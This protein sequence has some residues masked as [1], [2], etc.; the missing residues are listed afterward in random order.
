[1]TAS[2]G[3]FV[4]KSQYDEILDEYEMLRE[5]TS[6][7]QENYIK[8]SKAMDAIFVELSSVSRSTVSLKSDIESGQ[9]RMT[10]AEQ[11]ENSIADIKAQ[12]AELEALSTSNRQMRKTIANLKQVI[13]AKEEEI[14]VLKD[15][16]RQ[17]D[18]TISSQK[19]T[20][21]NQEVQISSQAEQIN[22]HLNTITQQKQELQ[23]QVNTQ[24]KLLYQAGIDFEEIADA[25]PEIRMK[26]NKTKVSNWTRLMY[27]HSVS[28]LN[29]ALR[30]GYQPA[31][32]AIERVQA[33]L[34]ALE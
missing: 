2:C 21:S 4:P 31:K 12:L 30:S 7:T 19:E 6:E 17:K 14:Q 26:S 18:D 1:M 10:Q 5:A 25:S 28:Y 8:Q 27:E 22:E 32:D 9:A 23:K 29:G 15:E 34:D 3:Q 24:A 20:I 16:I 11:I 13:V 33:K